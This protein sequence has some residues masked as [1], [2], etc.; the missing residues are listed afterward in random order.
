MNST[1]MT[2]SNVWTALFIAAGALAAIKAAISIFPP[3]T[4]APIATVL[5]REATLILGSLALGFA[6]LRWGKVTGAR[7]GWIAPNWRAVGWGLLC[8][9]AIIAASIAMIALMRSLG[10]VQNQ[11]V[12][13]E[14]AQRPIWVLALIALT[15]GISEEIVFRGIVLPQIEA[16][17]GLTWLGAVVS[18]AAFALMHLSGWGWSQ[19]VFAAVPGAVLTLFFLWKRNLAVVIIG[20]FLTD[21]IGLLA[22]V[23]QAQGH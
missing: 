22:V 17:S 10:I 14:M 19:V 9:L 5:L 11:T 1:P 15:A 8:G 20:H 13:G 3:L 4:T 23:A 16:A 6:A 12:L 7:M 21:L 2:R 18:L